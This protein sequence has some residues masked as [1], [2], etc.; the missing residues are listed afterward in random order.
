MKATN[1]FGSA[2]RRDG[3]ANITVVSE[4][5]QTYSRKAPHAPLLRLALISCLKTYTNRAASS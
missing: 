5:A 3:Q 2:Q 1:H 4:F